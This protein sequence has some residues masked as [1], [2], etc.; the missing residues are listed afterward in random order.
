[1]P[2][3]TDYTALTKVILLETEIFPALLLFSSWQFVSGG[4]GSGFPPLTNPKACGWPA[5]PALSRA[6]SATP[7]S[8]TA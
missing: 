7:R 2:N 1:M 3:I 4:G 8:A 6:P 5:R